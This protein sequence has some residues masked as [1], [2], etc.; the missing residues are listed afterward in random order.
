MKGKAEH[1]GDIYAAADDLGCDWSDILDYSANINPLG[2]P[3][4]LKK[5]LL[6]EFD[7]VQNYPDPFAAQWRHDLAEQL[8]LPPE[9]IIAGNGTTPL[10]YLTARVVAPRLAGIAAPAFAEYEQSLRHVGSKIKYI[11]CTARDDFDVIET[12]IRRL[13]DL[14]PDLVYLANP[15]SPAGRLIDPE[16]MQLALDLGRKQKTVVAVDEA[17]LDF[18]HAPSICRMITEHPRLAVFRSLTKFYALPG[19]RLGYMVASPKLAGRL[20]KASE[21]WSVNALAL[22]AGMFCLNQTDNYAEKTRTLVDQERTFLEKGIIETGLGRV[23]PSSANYLLVRLNPKGLGETELAAKM[24]K[25]GILIR[26]CASFQG[27]QGYIRLAVKSRKQNERLLDA[28]REVA[29]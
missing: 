28:I 19:L 13:F 25:K 23:T 9:L 22:A 24:Q 1:G 29:T 6:N 20:Q 3:K 5:Y 27:L 17:F 21:P 16:V 14:K 2:P 18:T 11:R 10:M 15:T 7:M 8:D 4:G 26:Q 12:T